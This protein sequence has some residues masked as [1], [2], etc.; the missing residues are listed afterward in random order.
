MRAALQMA[1]T[2]RRRARKAGEARTGGAHSG[3]SSGSFSPPPRFLASWQSRA[4]ARAGVGNAGDLSAA[5]E[6][7]A[8]TTDVYEQADAALAEASAVLRGLSQTPVSR[9]TAAPGAGDAALAADLAAGAAL[10]ARFAAGSRRMQREMAALRASLESL[11]A[12]APT[13]QARAL[14]GQALPAA[15][16]AL[17]DD[18]VGGSPSAGGSSAIPASAPVCMDDDGLVAFLSDMRAKYRLASEAAQTFGALSLM[19]T[20]DTPEGRNR[21][22]E[23]AGTPLLPAP[24]WRRLD[25]LLREGGFAGLAPAPQGVPG[26]AHAAG[27]L[28]AALEAALGAL[29]RR[30]ALAGELLAAGAAAAEREAAAAA[31]LR[32]L[33]QERDAAMRKAGAAA[34]A[35]GRGAEAASGSAQK[36]RDSA[37]SLRAEVQRL[38]GELTRLRADLRLRE[39]ADAAARKQ[40]AILRAEAA[41]VA[42]AAASDRRRAAAEHSKAQAQVAVLERTVRLRDARIAELEAA[43]CAGPNPADLD[44]AERQIAEAREKHRRMEAQAAALRTAVAAAGVAAHAH[45]A[46][47]ERLRGALLER[48][49]AD[50]ARASKGA[51]ALQ[52]MRRALSA[53]KGQAGRSAAGAVAAA[54]RELRPVEIAGHYEAQLEPLQEEAAGL[55]AEV[56]VLAGQLR[57]AQNQLAARRRGGAWREAGGDGATQRTAE[58]LRAATEALRAQAAAEA[59]A[60]EAARSGSGGELAR[61]VAYFQTLFSVPRLAGVLPAMNQAYQ[62]CEQARS[63]RRAQNSYLVPGD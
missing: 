33:R 3:S 31:A 9:Q 41:A 56:G 55:R 43:A 36:Q 23:T 7:A 26:G 61:I 29:G 42:S 45:E 16:Q 34:R 27:Q 28:A 24:H 38:Q 4:G 57:D 15:D 10:A 37:A 21:A 60:A 35:A 58:A 6:E 59:A 20:P 47:A 8:R 30:Q 14:G 18:G 25:D 11:G 13:T 44:A 22:V 46:A 53:H 5:L 2:K 12:G 62:A 51:A 1:Q 17:E 48:V 52:R 49:Q 54:A 50:E 32:R 40:V 39:A 19:G 63:F